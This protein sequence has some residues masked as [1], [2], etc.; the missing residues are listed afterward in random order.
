MKEKLTVS[1]TLTAAEAELQ[2]VF[3][4]ARNL[5]REDVQV[6]LVTHSR[7]P[8]DRVREIHS[9]LERMGKIPAIRVVRAITD[10][11]LKD[12]KEYIEAHTHVRHP[13]NPQ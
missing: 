7:S 5:C 13:Y 6:E 12:A 1:L 4:D 3:A 9:I 11:G 2:T 10:M 8:M